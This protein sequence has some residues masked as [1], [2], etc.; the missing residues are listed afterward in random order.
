MF[1][2]MCLTDESYPYEIFNPYTHS[3]VVPSSGKVFLTQKF[4]MRII[5]SSR[6]LSTQSVTTDKGMLIC[7]ERRNEVRCCVVVVLVG[8]ANEGAGSEGNVYCGFT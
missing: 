8:V 1:L 2:S 6:S 4:K 3:I 5:L 7:C